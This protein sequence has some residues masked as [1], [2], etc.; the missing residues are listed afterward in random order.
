METI[1]YEDFMTTRGSAGTIG[2]LSLSS[3]PTEALAIFDQNL[4]FS[5]LEIMLGA[6]IDIESPVLARRLTT[7]ELNIL[8]S[9]F[10]D[11]CP[12]LSRAFAQVK[13]IRTTLEKLESNARLIS[14]AKPDEE[15]I[16]AS[17]QVVIRKEIGKIYLLFP[18]AAFDPLLEQL[19]ELLK[20]S[21]QKG[22]TWKQIF[23]QQMQKVPLS[24][25]AKSGEFTITIRDLL[26]MRK[27]D[28]LEINYD[29]NQP[30]QI[31]VEGRHK[32]NALAGT[33]NGNKAINL[34]ELI[35]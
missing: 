9:P 32:F 6:A 15:V 35:E 1:R 28:V 18:T 22:S 13:E 11:L 23:S 3:L 17:L 24:V 12:D 16:V 31:L 20:V 26:Q 21:S 14:I 33:H 7:L 4:S 2:V 19:Q 34:T 8:R 5:I 25:T 10:A 27:G 29:P 30:L